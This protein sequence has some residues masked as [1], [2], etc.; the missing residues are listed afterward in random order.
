MVW[1]RFEIWSLGH[2]ANI[3]LQAARDLGV[4]IDNHLKLNKHVNGVTFHKEY[5]KDQEILDASGLWETIIHAF[6]TS[7]LDS[8]N[9]IFYGLP[10]TELNKLQRIQNTAT[11]LVTKSKKSEHITP[12][13]RGLHWLPIIARISFILILLTFKALHGQAPIYITEIIN[14]YI[15][16]R[17]IPSSDKTD[18]LVT[19]KSSIYPTAIYPSARSIYFGLSLFNTQMGICELQHKFSYSI[20]LELQHE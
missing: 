13:L 1:F 11:R 6:V 17:S 19:P 5:W 12:V 4:A 18:F 15:P 2:I 7:R 9:S 16:A 20:L 3:V 10:D 8:C 14:Q